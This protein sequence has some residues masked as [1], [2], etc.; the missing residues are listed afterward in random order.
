M[1]G[2]CGDTA[3]L[4]TTTVLECD[5]THQRQRGTREA[6]A[7][8]GRHI[9]LWLGDTAAL[10]L[11]TPQLYPPYSGDLGLGQNVA[12]TPAPVLLRVGGWTSDVP[13]TQHSYASWIKTNCFSCFCV[14]SSCFCAVPAAPSSPA[15]EILV[16]PTA[17]VMQR[18]RG[19]GSSKEENRNA[20]WQQEMPGQ[21]GARSPPEPCRHCSMVNYHSS[22]SHVLVSSLL[23]K[24]TPQGPSEVSAHWCCAHFPSPC[25]AL[26]SPVPVLHFG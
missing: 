6:Q 17:T 14:S 23:L 11:R 10:G 7:G 18:S 9:Q 16:F 1:K 8:C 20:L 21:M 22:C 25:P 19:G 3:K 26:I 4:P 12:D 15:Y 13:W 2:G 24:P 5:K